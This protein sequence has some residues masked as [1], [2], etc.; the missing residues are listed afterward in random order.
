[1]LS[2]YNNLLSAVDLF[3]DLFYN[4][5]DFREFARGRD[6]DDNY[7]VSKR[8]PRRNRPFNDWAL[9]RLRGGN[10][11]GEIGSFRDNFWKGFNGPELK[12]EKDKYVVT[13]NDPNLK[14]KE[15]NIDFHKKEKELLITT[16]EE[17]KDGNSSYTS[18]SENRLTLSKPVKYNDITADFK[19]NGLVI[20]VPKVEV[21]KD[22]DN[23][24]NVKINGIPQKK[25]IGSNGA[26]SNGESA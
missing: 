6:S 5:N 12:E 17:R 4:D 3:D 19:E 21:D 2:L 9:G 23:V 1:M 15:V 11:F 22:D 10:D 14:N 13:Y 16:N 8:T 25:A 20:V 24:Y 18:S 7:Q 26:S